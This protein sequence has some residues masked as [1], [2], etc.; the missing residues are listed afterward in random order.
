MEICSIS[1]GSSGNCIYVGTNETHLLID[2]GISGKKI[3]EGLEFF[4]KKPEDICG[5]LITHEHSDHI[6]GIGAFLKKY[7]VPI[8]G[9]IETLSAVKRQAGGK[10]IPV[11]LMIFINPGEEFN[12][13]DITVKV[14]ST[15]HDAAN[16]VC[17]RFS[18]GGQS[19][20]MATDL[21][22]YDQ[23]IME[24]LSDADILYLESNYDP[25]MLMVGSYPYYLKLRIDGNKGHLS[26][27]LSAE[28]VSKVM[29]DRLMG[30]IL[31][32]LS[33]DNNFPDLAYQTHL[34]MLNE[35][36]NF[37]TP[38]PELMVA[39][40]DIPSVRFSTINE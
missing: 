34:N 28:L 7:K 10:S 29:T 1:S 37:D 11:E 9:T 24:H 38:K 4:D 25:E 14:T 39:K 23:A 30:L 16:S 33:G 26:N 8:Y 27:D 13:G 21:G 40:R 15:S 22:C 35:F 36:W 31:A 20:A 2:T 19:I 32:H 6:K 17:Y 5:I 18:N 12:I 3:I